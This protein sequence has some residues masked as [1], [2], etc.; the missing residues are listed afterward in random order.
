MPKKSNKSWG[1]R[2]NRGNEDK[3]YFGHDDRVGRQGRDRRPHGPIKHRVSFKTHTPHN[4]SRNLA[5]ANLDDDIPMTSNNNTRQ[6]GQSGSRRPPPLRESSWYRV[7]IP[8]GQKYEKDFIINTLLNYITPDVFVPILYK[9]S[10]TDASFYIDDYKTAVALQSCDYKITMSD[11]FKLQVKVK[12][13]FPI[14]DIDDKLKERLKQAMGKRYVQDTNALNLSKFHRDPDLCSDYFCALFHPIMLMTVLDIVAEHIPN[15]EAL[16]LEGNKLQNIERL[17]VLTKKFSKLKI[18]FIGDNKIRDIHQLDAIKDL[19]LDELKLTG[20][21]VC[22]K[23]KSRQ[24]D[25]ISDVR[26]RFPKLLRLDGIEL[27]RP[28]VFDVVDEAAKTPPSQRMFIADAKAQEIASQ[29]LQ[30]Y[31]TIFDSENRQPLL[32]AYNEHALFSMTINTSNNNK[33]NGY[34]LENR[35]LFRI[36]DTIRRQKFLK[37][38][39]LPVVSF[40]SEMPRT[41][42][43][44]NTF[45]MDLSLVTQTIMFI[46]ITGYFQQLDNKE[47]LIRYFNRTFIIV[48][49]GEGYCIRNEQLHISQPSEV[50]L[51]ELHQQLNQLNTQQTQ[52]E[53]ETLSSTEVTKPVPT[54]LDDEVKKQMTLMLSQQTNMNLEWSLKCL[55]ETQWIYDNAIAAFQEFFKRGQIP[56]QAFAK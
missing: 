1:G 43:L 56:P 44:L 19:K 41:R 18:L 17:N 31:F 24:N 9:T 47:E 35:N 27:P 25:Y 8:Y 23:Y 14:Y 20:N 30:Q 6:G 29:F 12:P 53:T 22:N 38:G 50:Q 36:N 28:I 26:R 46:T 49:E 32:D 51:K 39:R 40:I 3:G 13:G 4:M 16:N 7:T 11:G 21:P 34:Y 42:H 33:L 15:L 48:P 5:F 45:T 2:N 52:P 37:Q 55:Q 10:A 54:E